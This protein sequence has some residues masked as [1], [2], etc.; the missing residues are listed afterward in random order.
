M[1]LAAIPNGHRPATGTKEQ[2]MALFEGGKKS[3]VVL[4]VQ[5]SCCEEWSEPS[6]SKQDGKGQKKARTA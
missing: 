3:T 2:Q 1:L 4:S 6:S 5:L